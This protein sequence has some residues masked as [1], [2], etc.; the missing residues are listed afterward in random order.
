MHT[1]AVVAKSTQFQARGLA[2]AA[3]YRVFDDLVK[4]QDITT[5][6]INFATKATATVQENP[7]PHEEANRIYQNVVIAVFNDSNKWMMS[8]VILNQNIS[9]KLLPWCLNCTIDQKRIRSRKSS[10]SGS[11]PVPQKRLL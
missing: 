11:P 3:L 2:D 1:T 10:R 9:N 6:Y 7:S 8:N 5:S 4:G